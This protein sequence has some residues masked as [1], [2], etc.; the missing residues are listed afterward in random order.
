MTIVILRVVR[1]AVESTVTKRPAAGA[2]F[3]VRPF[4]DDFGRFFGG[5]ISLGIR[6]CVQLGADAPIE[7]RSRSF[8]TISRHMCE[9]LKSAGERRMTAIDV[10]NIQNAA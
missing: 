2:V 8:S 3:P 6:S 1:T 7:V 10:L 5:M 4:L 9:T